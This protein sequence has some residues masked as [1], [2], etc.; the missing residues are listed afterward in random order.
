MVKIK[1]LELKNKYLFWLLFLQVLLFIL[2]FIQW[3]STS[4]QT[5][6]WFIIVLP[7][8]SSFFYVLV[9]FH[10]YILKRGWFLSIPF[11]V[12]VFIS[13]IFFFS[14]FLLR[15]A[16]NNLEKFSAIDY[17][18][19]SG[20]LFP[21]LISTLIFGGVIGYFVSLLFTEPNKPPYFEIKDNTICFKIN[22]ETSEDNK[23]LKIL[24]SRT[25]RRYLNY[26]VFRVIDKNIV[27]FRSDK[28]FTLKYV[29]VLIGDKDIT[30]F[31]FLKDGFGYLVNKK[32]LPFFKVI[33]DNIFN[34]ETKEINSSF[35]NAFENY[36]KP[37]KLL[38]LL[39]S[40]KDIRLSR[41][42]YYCIGGAI[43]VFIALFI[44][45]IVPN[46]NINMGINF[47]TQSLIITTLINLIISI[48]GGIVV[49]KIFSPKTKKK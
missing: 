13:Q 46:M 31:P 2:S 25:I 16:S 14:N 3:N 20:F 26:Y 41:K 23:A 47:N 44:I 27:I 9:S 34:L 49:L 35:R 37:H 33:G 11:F 19:I 48:A 4:E 36:T 8:F 17:F 42:D 43:I 7:F 45:F 29:F 12:L 1:G 21:Y 40:V 18:Q 5:R 24:F 32:E 6:L 38:S 15:T 10:Y 39:K 22:K 28:L 30:F